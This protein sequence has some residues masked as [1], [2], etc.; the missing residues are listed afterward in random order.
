[1]RQK[2]KGSKI[3]SDL[4][5]LRATAGPTPQC[6]AAALGS[7]FF[8]DCNLHE[9]SVQDTGASKFFSCIGFTQRS[10]ILSLTHAGP[11]S[12]PRSRCSGCNKC[13]ALSKYLYGSSSPQYLS[14][15]PI[16]AAP[17]PGKDYFI[18]FIP[19][20]EWSNKAGSPAKTFEFLVSAYPKTADCL[21]ARTRCWWAGIKVTWWVHLST[22]R[23]QAG[24][25]HVS[26]MKIN[27]AHLQSVS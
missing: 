21:A 24:P 4:H 17:H 1:M 23:T 14:T 7:Q 5:T 11:D 9:N 2:T 13:S 22:P 16:W 3:P 18:S 8:G 20:E 15:V 6:D 27:M 19:P 25:P 10:H 26:V 12:Q